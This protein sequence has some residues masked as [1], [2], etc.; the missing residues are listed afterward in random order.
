M[1]VIDLVV[2]DGFFLGALGMILNNGCKFSMNLNS[3]SYT[4]KSY[5]HRKVESEES[6]RQMTD[7]WSDEQKFHI[8]HIECSMKD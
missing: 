6:C 7:F 1:P 3:E 5:V 4:V 8:K 2:F